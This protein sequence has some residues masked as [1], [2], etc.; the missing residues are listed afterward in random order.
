M[1]GYDPPAVC[2]NGSPSIWGEALRLRWDIRDVLIYAVGIGSHDL[3]FVY[4][5]HPDFAVFPTFPI[6]FGTLGAA[7]FATALPPSLGPLTID[8]ERF[9]EMHRPLPTAGTAHI[10]SRVVGIHP[11][12]KGSSFVEYETLVSDGADV[13]YCRL[14]TGQYRR[15]VNQLG[16]IE[17]FEGIGTTY[18]A[19]LVPP[20]AP[21][22]VT[23]EQWIAD[24]QAMIYRLSGD[25][26]PLHIDTAAAKVGGFDQPILHGL[27]T[28]G[29]C[30]SMLLGALCDGDASRFK[31]IK[32]RF[33]S[34][35]FMSSRLRVH[36]WH[37]GPGRVLF[38]AEVEGRLVVSNAFFEFDAAP[39]PSKL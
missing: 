3:R 22:D 18:S 29:H 27:C 14:V 4:E 5:G 12:P 2:P 21:P 38:Q 10:R 16:D 1:P 7:S 28:F 15:G 20:S 33:S 23:C 8:A 13:P 34:P 11:R 37:D 6:R 26:N 9:L 32:V 17:P 30:A 36:A 19:K 35:V 24:N 39:S 31:K 25:F